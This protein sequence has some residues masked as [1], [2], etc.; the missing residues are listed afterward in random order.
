MKLR[1]PEKR[2]YFRLAEMLGMPVARLLDE[3]SSLEISEWIVELR[4][5]AEDAKIAQQRAQSRARRRR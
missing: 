4:W 1:H 2:L 3:V 5:R